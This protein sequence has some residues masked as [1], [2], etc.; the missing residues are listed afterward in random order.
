MENSMKMWMW[1]MWLMMGTNEY[2]NEPL[3]STEGRELLVTSWLTITFSRRT[4]IH[5]FNVYSHSFRLHPPSYMF[6]TWNH[7]VSETGSTSI[8]REHKILISW[9]PWQTETVDRESVRLVFISFVW[10]SLWAVII[11][12]NNLNQLKAATVRSLCFLCSTD[13]ILTYVDKP[14][15]RGLMNNKLKRLWNEVVMS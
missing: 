2:Y 13:Q 14:A 7:N 11:S 4:F 3:G 12:L 8:I 9:V 5:R 6:S 1:F 10:F 15:S